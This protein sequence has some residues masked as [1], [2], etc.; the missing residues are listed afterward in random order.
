LEFLEPSDNPAMLGRLGSFEIL[1]TI[2]AG[3][4]GVVLKGYDR[5]LNRYVA[6]KVLAPHL[7]HNAAARKRFAR[8]AQAAAAI[9]HP[10]VVPIHAVDAAGKLPYLVMP[11][12]AGESLQQRLDR[13]G[14]LSLR[15][16]LRIGTQA[17]LGLAAAHAQGLVHRDIKPANILLEHGV[18]RVM[19]TD[20][21]LAR[22][23]DDA[24]LTRS[25]VIAGT[26]QYMAPEQARGDTVDH[27]ADLFSLGSV[28]Y[29]MCAGHPPF[30]AETMLGVLR[31]VCD[32]PPRGIREVNSDVPDWLA[33]IIDRLLEKNPERRY[34]SAV[35]V[36]ELLERCLAHV[37]QPTVL[38]LPA[39]LIK[40]QGARARRQIAQWFTGIA[41]A[42][43]LV[44]AG[45]RMATW[46]GEL[47][48]RTT[49]PSDAQRVAAA[50]VAQASPSA[51]EESVSSSDASEKP[52]IAN[53]EPVPVWDSG[54]DPELWAITRELGRLEAEATSRRA[55]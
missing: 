2:G 24:S 25:T 49:E 19:L 38:P 48:E 16:T 41:A 4:F 3:A 43:L 50:P 5:E 32:E 15:E 29:A 12:I 23:M 36:A 9:V 31:R 30:R 53:D 54:I 28:L 1:E 44:F 22:T 37:Q 17:A 33:Q 47:P 52:E 18:D 13:V 35:S 8:E 55:E 7:A 10:H 14:P 51:P 26:P 27:R 11:F 42:S 45:Y 34:S 39:E 6:V 46:P 21:G 40:P 20:F